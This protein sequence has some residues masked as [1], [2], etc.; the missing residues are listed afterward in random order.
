MFD[1]PKELEVRQLAG[2]EMAK[3]FSVGLWC[4]GT[5]MKYL[6]MQ[7]LLTKENCSLLR[8]IQPSTCSQMVF[9]YWTMHRK[10]FVYY[11][12][13]PGWVEFEEAN[14][15]F[16]YKWAPPAKVH[17]SKGSQIATLATSW[18]LGILLYFVQPPSFNKH[19]RASFKI[20]FCYDILWCCYLA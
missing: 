7:D 19:G 13:P 10:S 16:F 1:T 18:V 11:P 14:S 2:K 4:P 17:W 5:L 3:P 6:K 9:C 12:W 15:K 20:G 8:K